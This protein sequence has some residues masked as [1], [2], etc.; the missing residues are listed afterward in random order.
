MRLLT[1]RSQVRVPTPTHY[2]VVLLAH[3]EPSLRTVNRFMWRASKLELVYLFRMESPRMFCIT[4][5]I[6]ADERGTDNL[7]RI[8]VKW[9]CVADR[10]DVTQIILQLNSSKVP[11]IVKPQGSHTSLFKV[12][13]LFVLMKRQDLDLLKCVSPRRKVCTLHN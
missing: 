12:C 9:Y 8:I 3:L 5:R 1:I 2:N 6:S 13:V 4:T 11:W 10:T 7:V